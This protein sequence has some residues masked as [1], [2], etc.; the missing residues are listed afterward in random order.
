MSETFTLCKSE[1]LQ[2]ASVGL[3]V[4]KKAGLGCKIG[5]HWIYRV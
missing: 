2:H 4:G 5:C 1:Y 3:S